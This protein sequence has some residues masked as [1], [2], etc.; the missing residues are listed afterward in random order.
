[1]TP[2]EREHFKVGIRARCYEG[3]KPG[4]TQTD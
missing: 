2:E 3:A 1:M 4:D